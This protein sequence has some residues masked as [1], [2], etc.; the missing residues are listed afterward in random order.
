MFLFSFLQFTSA[1]ISFFFFHLCIFTIYAS[2]TTFLYLSWYIVRQLTAIYAYTQNKCHNRTLGNEWLSTRTPTHTLGDT[3]SDS[4]LH[5]SVPPPSSLFS[6]CISQVAIPQGGRQQLASLSGEFNQ[7]Q[8]FMFFS[9]I[10]RW[11]LSWGMIGSCLARNVP[12]GRN[13]SQGRAGPVGAPNRRGKMECFQL[14]RF[15]IC[16]LFGYNN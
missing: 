7:F 5:M 4:Y 9:C 8:L 3:P 15:V 13:G 1:Y 11:R 14:T 10:D 6:L 16:F 12:N 2:N